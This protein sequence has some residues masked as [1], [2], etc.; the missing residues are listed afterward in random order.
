MARKAINE[1][2]RGGEYWDKRKGHEFRQ[3]DGRVERRHKDEN[4]WRK[5]VLVARPLEEIDKHHG[6]MVVTWV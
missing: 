1:G 2:S 5:H 4:V 3:V 6:P